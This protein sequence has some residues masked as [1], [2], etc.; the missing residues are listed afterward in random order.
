MRRYDDQVG[1]TFFQRDH[2][3]Q[4]FDFPGSS[5][6][7]SQII[8]LAIQSNAKIVAGI[9]NSNADGVPFVIVARLNPNGRPDTTFG[10]AGVVET[11]IGSLAASVFA[12]QPD[13]K[14]RDSSRNRV[15][16]W[17]GTS[18]CRLLLAVTAAAYAVMPEHLHLLVSRPSR[19]SAAAVKVLG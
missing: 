17:L 18:F 9:S 15:N 12:L 11:Q 1:H 16:N 5:S 4:V 6:G 2:A 14:W 10:S 8:G 13:G 3:Q 7:P 19:A